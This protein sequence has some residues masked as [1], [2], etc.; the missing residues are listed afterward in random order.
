MKRL[1]IVIGNSTVKAGLFDE[2]EIISQKRWDHVHFADTQ[3]MVAEFEG[4]G[5]AGAPAVICSVVP[6]LEEIAGILLRRASCDSVASVEPASGPMSMTYRT[7]ETLGADRYCA[8][9]AGRELYGSP[10]IVID[11]G[12]ATTINV[13]DAEGRFAG[14]SISPGIGTSLRVLHERTA[15]LPGVEEEA[16]PQLIGRDTAECMRSGVLYGAR[17][18]LEGITAGIRQFTGSG[19][20]I[21]LTGG[22]AEALLGMGPSGGF[23]HDELIV[24]RGAIFYLLLAAK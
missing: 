5:C 18:A 23:V 6:S 11:C 19:T 3:Y 1:A 17:Y 16:F 7:P 2:M 13:V 8:A 14:G 20:P 15:Q 10:V 12:T 9:L 22:D 4:L 24:L 21:I